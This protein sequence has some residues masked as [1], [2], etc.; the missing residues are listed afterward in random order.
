MLIAFANTII[1]HPNPRLWR[2][3]FEPDY[4]QLTILN[5]NNVEIA[6]PM[7]LTDVSK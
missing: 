3:V 2:A 5:N 6:G 4:S 7:V 1:G